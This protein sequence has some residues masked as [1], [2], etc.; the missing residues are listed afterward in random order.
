MTNI[1]FTTVVVVFTLLFVIFLIYNNIAKYKCVEGNCVMSVYGDY[2]SKD[3]CLTSCKKPS[4][5]EV[6]NSTKGLKKVQF[7]VPGKDIIEGS[8][9]VII[10][11]RDTSYICDNTRR[12]VEVPGASTGA[13][14]TQEAC[15]ANCSQPVE[16][17]YYNVVPPSYYYPQ[18]LY[19]YRRPNYWR[20]RGCGR[21]GCRRRSPSFSIRP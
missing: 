15:A 17:T 11:E 9:E 16:Q 13:F 8:E 10:E 19:Y 20:R 7:N 18:S 6:S 14:T 3:D 4:K 2:K 1:D 21:G 12:C 5:E